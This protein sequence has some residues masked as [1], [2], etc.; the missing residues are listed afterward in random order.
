MLIPM[1][2]Q[3]EIAMCHPDDRRQA[4]QLALGEIDA[5]QG[6]AVLDTLR[7]LATAGVDVFRT[8]HVAR[9]P[10]GILGATWVQPQVGQTGTYWLPRFVDPVAPPLER[11]LAQ[12]AIDA[13]HTLPIVLVQSLLPEEDHQGARLLQDCGFEKLANLIYLFA[14]VLPLAAGD[15]PDE[16]LQLVPVPEVDRETLKQVILAT[17]VD[18]LDC[19]AL[20]GIR[21]VDDALAGYAATGTHD[22]ALWFVAY[23][24]GDPAGVLLLTQH[25]EANHWEVVYMGVAPEQRGRRLGRNLL[26]Y[27]QKRAH[28][29]GID[30]LVLAVDD[31]NWPA[32]RMYHDAGFRE[33]SRRVAYTLQLG[34]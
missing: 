17:Y 18:T 24:Q 33:W 34:K 29:A 3:I 11:R 19:P 10:R 8:L 22:P 31:A 30:N 6:A 27:V 5:T 15:A 21:D 20:E 25:L 16:N 1:A 12:S 13:A 7:P 28:A 26:A 4:L 9:S 14:P 32:C 23:W 2:D